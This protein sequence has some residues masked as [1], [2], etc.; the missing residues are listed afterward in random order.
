[1]SCTG[2][3]SYLIGFNECQ[4]RSKYNQ[5]QG[6]GGGGRGGNGLNFGKG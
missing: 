4:G 1:M 5:W 6:G 2:G 3:D